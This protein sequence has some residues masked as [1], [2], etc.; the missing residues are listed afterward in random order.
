MA[1]LVELQEMETEEGALFLLR[2]ARYIAED[3]PL[4]AAAKADRA[5]AKEITT[6]LDG[7]TLALDQ[8]AAYIEETGCGLSG[9]LNL[10]RDYAPE[11]LGRRGE[12]AS[13]HR[14]PVDKT[15]V[16]SFENIEKADPRAAELLRFCAFLDA[17]GIPEELFGNGAEELG[18]VLEPLGSDALAFNGAV[19]EILKYSLL[20]RDPN[21]STL[22][23]HR[24]VQV[25]LKQAMDEGTQ[26]LWAE[27]AVRAVNR[28]FPTPE[29]SNWPVCDRLL[30][31]AHACKELIN[32]C[33]F[34]FPEGAGL[35]NE[36]GSYL[37]QRGRYIDAERLYQRALVIRE[38]A[39]GP[40]H[41]QVAQVLNNLA[42]L[43]NT[44]GQYAL[45]PSRSI[46]EGCAPL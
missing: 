34:E 3:L 35:L 32:Q 10:Y 22:E 29:F 46:C 24:L 28:A 20:R 33:G 27:R 6:Q 4:D 13:D 25:V 21:T 1:R 19:S 23:I 40:S 26:R 31:Q 41:P 16:L 37:F 2:R 5:T 9:Y 42:T 45:L 36:A 17:D 8:A 15:W 38:K 14:D 30:P 43:Y 39:L 7:L 44:Q 11:L 18:P 12:L